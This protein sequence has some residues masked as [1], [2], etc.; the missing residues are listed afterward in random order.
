MKEKNKK[1]V[2]KKSKSEKKTVVKRRTRA[3]NDIELYDLETSAADLE[4]TRMFDSIRD[5]NIE[6]QLSSKIQPTTKNKV[7]KKRKNHKRTMISINDI[8]ILV[9]GFLYLVSAILLIIG[10]VRYVN[11]SNMKE[12][13]NYLM[14][15]MILVVFATILISS[16][17]GKGNVKTIFG[18]SINRKISKRK[19]VIEY[20]KESVFLSLIIT[21][22][23]AILISA[24]NLFID[25]YML[26][27]N[28]ALNVILIFMF[29]YIVIC[30]LCYLFCYLYFEHKISKQ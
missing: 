3:S 22:V 1:V 5:C 30:I 6:K 24:G 8:K 15:V 27:S 25:F 4:Y 26:T 29:M 11:V 19:R 17:V 9:C 10:L 18:A 21:T 13:S 28:V 16:E 2:E 7:I 23:I 20:F 14:L 12:C